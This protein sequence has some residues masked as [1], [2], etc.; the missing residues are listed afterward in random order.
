MRGQGAARGF[1]KGGDPLRRLKRYVVRA[2]NLRAVIRRRPAKA[3]TTNHGLSFCRLCGKA[4]RWRRLEQG[5]TLAGDELND[6]RTVYAEATKWC[7][8]EYLAQ[9][10]SRKRRLAFKR[11]NSGR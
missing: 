2:G 8:D 7:R 9:Q 4:R 5:E 6:F 11:G 10:A 3:G 1:E